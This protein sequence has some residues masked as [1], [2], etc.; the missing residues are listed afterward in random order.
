MRE[1]FPGFPAVPTQTINSRIARFAR[2]PIACPPPGRAAIGPEEPPGPPMHTAHAQRH[3]GCVRLLAKLSLAKIRAFGPAVYVL[4][5]EGPVALRIPRPHPAHRRARVWPLP[6][7]SPRMQPV[8]LRGGLTAVAAPPA[9]GARSRPCARLTDPCARTRRNLRFG[10]A[11]NVGPPLA[12][13]PRALGAI[14]RTAANGA[15]YQPGCAKRA[16][17]RHLT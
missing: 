10:S 14:A 5:Q 12:L 13:G 3:A 11:G 2:P 4:G 8:G 15:T 1:R 6:T 7:P 16:G 17:A 9:T